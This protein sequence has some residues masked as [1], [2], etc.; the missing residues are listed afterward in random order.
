MRL[1]IEQSHH[2]GVQYAEVGLGLGARRQGRLDAAEKH[3]RNWL[4]WCRRW[5]GDAG[6]ALI[7]AE[8]GFIAEQRGDTAQALA[9]HLNGFRASRSTMDPRAIALALEGLAGAQALAGH[10][11]HAAHLLGMAAALRG[12]AGA[13]LPP[14]ERG[15]VERITAATRQ[16]LG[17]KDFAAAYDHGT[18]TTFDEL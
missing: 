17:A 15:D 1:A 6:V 12:S 5:D 18:G 16:A 14:A 3:L 2:R 7:L 4:D 13:P 10:H 9:L 8:L 11:G